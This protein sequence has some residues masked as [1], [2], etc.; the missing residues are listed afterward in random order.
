MRKS[1][2]FLCTHNSC[3]SQMCE[4]LLREK[5]GDD[6]EVFSAGTDATNVNPYAIMVI[7]EIGIDT[8]SLYSKNTDELI[9]GRFDLVVTVCDNAK[10]NCPFFPGAKEYIH[11]GFR[12]PPDLVEEGMDPMDAFRMIRDEISDWIDSYFF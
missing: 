2:L 5:G 3:R 11:K 1:I 9:D 10:E 4:A 6:F 7:E 12:D 8:S